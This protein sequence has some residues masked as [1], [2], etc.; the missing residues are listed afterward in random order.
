[1][2]TY[3]DEWLQNRKANGFSAVPHYFRDGDY[4]TL[5]LT[6]ER[7]YA[8]RVDDLLTVYYSDK[9]GELVGCKVKGVCDLLQSLRQNFKVTIE[10]GNICLGLL[11]LTAAARSNA[12]NKEKYYWL[13]E[14]IGSIILPSVP[15]ARAA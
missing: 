14:R 8:K 6:N 10:D 12:S 3:L 15:V 4:I 11:F 13:G 9:N 1:M 5:F 2:V 7:C